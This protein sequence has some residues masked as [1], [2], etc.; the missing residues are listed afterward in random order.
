MQNMIMNWFDP[1]KLRNVDGSTLLPNSP[2]E[3]Q[4]RN[5]LQAPSK[6]I[7]CEV[8]P[9]PFWKFWGTA[10]VP[11]TQLDVIDDTSSPEPGGRFHS[12]QWNLPTP[13]NQSGRATFIAATDLF[14]GYS[15]ELHSAQIWLE[16]RRYGTKYAANVGAGASGGVAK[17]E[18]QSTAERTMTDVWVAKTVE[19]P[20]V[21]LSILEGP[22]VYSHLSELEREYSAA[23]RHSE[24]AVKDF[25]EETLSYFSDRPIGDARAK[26]D[27]APHK[28]LRILVEI[29]DRPHL[30]AVYCVK[31]QSVYDGS[32]S[33]TPP[34]FL[35][36]QGEK[37]VGT[38]LT[39]DLLP[40][41]HFE[42]LRQFVELEFDLSA[43]AE[44]KRLDQ[45]E[46]WNWV[47]RASEVLGAASVS[48]ALVLAS[49][50]NSRPDFA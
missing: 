14:D 20:P 25:S 2:V 49:H 16:E 23:Y 48:E 50:G 33:L 24:G 21:V 29:P 8:L 36:R 46:A 37:L 44:E 30:R 9:K 15:G 38:H 39:L 34:R 47:V 7:V 35:T 17:I 6:Y 43:L 19:D 26:W 41:D 3:L 28:P 5:H 27:L 40:N 11:V 45:L 10:I 22:E 42:I 4:S 32:I 1:Q 31:I 13:S 12:S 18:S